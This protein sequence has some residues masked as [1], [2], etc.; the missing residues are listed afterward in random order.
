MKSFI[1]SMV[2]VLAV[3][4]TASSVHAQC[5]PRAAVVVGGGFGGFGGFVPQS[6][7]V[8]Q[9]TAFFSGGNV[10]FINTPQAFVAQPFVAAPFVATPFVNQVQQINVRRGALGRVRQINVRTSARP[11]AVF[12]VGASA[13]FIR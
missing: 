7:V 10:A 9:S 13:L 2:V 1:A 12:N 4:V 8:P 11:Q 3:F 5:G 6:V